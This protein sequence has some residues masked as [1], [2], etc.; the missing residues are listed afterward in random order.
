MSEETLFQEALSHSRQKRAAFLEHAC[1]GRPELLAAVEALLA[2]H[3]KSGNILDTPPAQSFEPAPGPALPGATLDHVLSPEILV[4]II[5]GNP[6]PKVIDF[7]VAKAIAGKLTDQSMST[8]FGAVI[9]TLEYMSPEQ[10]GCSG[11]DVD[12]RADIYSLGAILY[13]LLTGLRP[14]EAD[15]LKNAAIPSADGQTSRN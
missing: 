4:T 7:G 10:T 2:A 8:Q 12:T 6:I 9:G 5:D 1:A 13:E 11:V 14:I 15:R 3:D